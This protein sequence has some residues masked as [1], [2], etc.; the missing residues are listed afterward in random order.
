MALER[1]RCIVGVNEIQ[2]AQENGQE[3]RRTYIEL[4]V[5]QVDDCHLY[6]DRILVQQFKYPAKSENR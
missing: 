5:Q 4:T 2:F 1:H 3:I 6:V